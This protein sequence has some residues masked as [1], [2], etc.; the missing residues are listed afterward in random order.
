MNLII[1]LAIKWQTDGLKEQTRILVTR[2]V[3][4]DGDVATRNH[5]GRVAERVR[6]NM[7]VIAVKR[8]YAS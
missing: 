3:G 6:T 8:A 1:E 2:G 5:L 4:F 7:S